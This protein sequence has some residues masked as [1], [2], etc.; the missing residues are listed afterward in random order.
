MK[1][2]LDLQDTLDRSLSLLGGPIRP[3][4]RDRQPDQALQERSRPVEQLEARD[5]KIVDRLARATLGQLRLAS[6]QAG[7]CRSAAL[8][9]NGRPA[10][11]KQ[12]RGQENREARGPKSP[13]QRCPPNPNRRHI[14][15]P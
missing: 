7:G 5:P 9:R 13:V 6:L 4:L 12:R 11:P 15:D 2:P 1:P 3:A 10:A 14:L 8:P